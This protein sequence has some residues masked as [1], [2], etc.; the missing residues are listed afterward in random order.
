[1]SIFHSELLNEYK[2]PF[3]IWHRVTQDDGYGGYTSIW[4]RG[5]TFEGILT[6][7]ASLTATVAGIDQNTNYY[8]LKV[9]RA[10]PLEFHSIIQN[11]E[12]QKY[13]RVTSG[14]TLES[15]RMS[16]MDMKILSLEAFE[17]VDVEVSDG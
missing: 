14:D 6:E 10:V 11:L 15:P 3:V 9:Q 5:A 1:M 16:A 8:G 17:P 7:D 2:K 4:T 13:Y 12:D